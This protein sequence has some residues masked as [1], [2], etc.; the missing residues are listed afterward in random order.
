VG[1]WVGGYNKGV[2]GCGS[3]VVCGMCV[4]EWMDSLHVCV[5]YAFFSVNHVYVSVPM[6]MTSNPRSVA[7]TEKS[8]YTLYLGVNNVTRPKGSERVSGVSVSVSVSV[9]Q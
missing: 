9:T 6:Y 8:L 5:C 2:R 4:Y 7:G 1:E 3:V